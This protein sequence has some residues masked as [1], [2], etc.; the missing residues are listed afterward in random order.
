MVC[1]ISTTDSF[2]GDAESSV[3]HYNKLNSGTLQRTR[4]KNP[5]RIFDIRFCFMKTSCT[6]GI[7]LQIRLESRAIKDQWN[8]QV[9]EKLLGK[10]NRALIGTERVPA[11]SRN[12]LIKH[13]LCVSVIIMKREIMRFRVESFSIG[14]DNYSLS[15]YT[16]IDASTV[17][18]Y[19]YRCN[20]WQ[21]WGDRKLHYNIIERT[22]TSRVTDKTWPLWC[23]FIKSTCTFLYHVFL[24]RNNPIFML[25]TGSFS[26][27]KLRFGFPDIQIVAPCRTF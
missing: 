27:W 25:I 24:H 10:L 13:Q 19:R 14:A 18:Y 2:C 21:W 1:T 11:S 15:R 5:E 8:C 20:C 26:I 12:Q 17:Y 22:A 16:I 9:L 4:K 3:R 7:Y 6:C 23:F